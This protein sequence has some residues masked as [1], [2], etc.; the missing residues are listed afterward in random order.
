MKA[1]FIA[2]KDLGAAARSPIQLGLGLAAP[3]LITALVHF[4]FGGAGTTGI[5]VP[6]TRVALVDADGD[7]AD[8]AGT[9]LVR[10][11]ESDALAGLVKAHRVG[12]LAAARRALEAGEV[13]VV[14]VIPAG[15]TERLRDGAR[16]A[17]VDLLHDPTLT[18]GPGVVKEIVGQ[19][20]DGLSGSRLAGD[21][22]A[23]A[24]AKA[25]RPVDGPVAVA[26]ARYVDWNRRLA[27]AAMRAGY[28]GLTFEDASGR[29][30]AAAGTGV[31]GAIM[32]GMM[33]FF[34]FF[35]AANGTLS[36][37]RESE[38]GT[39]PRLFTTPT[40]V[41]TL[42][43]GKLAAVTV[44]VLVQ[45]GLLL[46][47]ASLLFGLTWGSPAAAAVATV[48]LAAAASGFGVLLVSFARNAKQAGPVFGAVLA[49][50]GMAGG[51]FSA[52]LP[53][54]PP[55]LE[56]VSAFLPQGWALRAFQAAL[57]GAGTTEVLTASAVA[58]AMGLLCFAVGAV[59]LRRRFA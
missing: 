42:L 9:Q 34:A 37:L 48:G 2:L 39:L 55:I 33:I 26:R 47:A 58:A 16:A 57:S 25:G 27:E 6:E 17:E 20:L 18:I 8:R 52:A 35:A 19:L 53:S 54:P 51:L 12:S 28:P 49:G 41:W 40:P 1:L 32:M 14:L 50:A 3:L 36:I 29:E 46:V 21:T 5:H 4:A 22:V 7:G 38:A 45:V 13:D 10:F 15:F 24:L 11:F 44:M 43:G 56:R 59:F 30:A 31:V 23:A